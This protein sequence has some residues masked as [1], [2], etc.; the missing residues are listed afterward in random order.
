[1]EPPL[2]S[3]LVAILIERIDFSLVTLVL[4]DRNAT[5]CRIEEIWSDRRRG[6]GHGSTLLDALCAAAD[7]S[8]IDLELVCHSLEYDLDEITDPDE[9]RRLR[10]LNREKLGN[11]HIEAWYRRRG[12]VEI[13]RGDMGQPIMRRQAAA[14]IR[15]DQQGDPNAL[16]AE[17][18]A[19]AAVAGPEPEGQRTDGSL[20]V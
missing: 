11:P 6:A 10:D 19:E 14:S 13:G 18:I 15:Q 3:A 17:A 4:S 7:H 16:G 1:M 20:D 5:T 12:F 2:S 9:V 8:R